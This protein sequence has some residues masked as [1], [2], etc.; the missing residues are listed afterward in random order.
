MVRVAFRA[1]ASPRIGIGHV[2][3]C[4]TL[5]QLIARETASEILFI[6]N[7]DLPESVRERIMDAGFILE[8]TNPAD[9]FEWRSDVRRFIE[10]GG[11]GRKRKKFD[12]VVADHYSIDRR[13]EAEVRC[14]ARRILV[15]DDLADRPHECDVL[16]DQNLIA[17]MEQRYLGLVPEGCRLF[18]GPGYALLREEFFEA[19]S[20]A[21]ERTELRHV[22]VNF[23]GSDPTG[24]AFKVL[25]ALK[26]T[27]WADEP[28]ALGLTAILFHVVAGPANPRLNELA[29]RCRGM[30]NVSFYTE[31]KD[32]ARF[33]AGMDLAV[34]AGGVSMWERAFMGVPSAVIAVADNQI[35][36]AEE[37]AKRGI[38]WYLG[39]CDAVTPAAIAG[40]LRTLEENPQ[41]LGR[42]S[43]NALHIMQT[44]RNASLHPIVEYI[45]NV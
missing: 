21:R 44:L 14:V 3:R 29:E 28:A 1:D 11:V 40:L 7:R 17:G 34:G 45:L 16:L 30:P 18:L 25:V 4:L 41:E 27:G 10:L 24:E 43:R 9:D 15:I 5:A 13:W 8:F 2:M 38:V 35:P 33:L 12:W 22:L 39:K 31:I 20:L 37:T 36:A 32:M 23:G 26:E 42:I 6:C 19:K